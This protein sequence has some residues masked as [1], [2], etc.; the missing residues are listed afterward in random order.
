MAS[1]YDTETKAQALALLELGKP[2]SHVAQEM[3][4]PERTVSRWAMR[5]RQMAAEEGDRLL[6]DEDYRLAVR[7]SQLLHDALDQMEGKEDLWK[8]LVPLNIVRGTAID[9]ILKRQ[10][11]KYQP[12]LQAQKITINFISQKPPDQESPDVVEGEVVKD[13]GGDER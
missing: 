7:T 4:V 10:E 8:Y 13:K 9:K 11:P 2:A 3:R 12:S 5:W 6:T 1:Q